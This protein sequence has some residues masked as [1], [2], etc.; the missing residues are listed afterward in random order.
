M[1]HEAIQQLGAEVWQWRNA[2]AFHTGDDIPRVDRAADW[3]P[4]FTVSAIDAMQS[5]HADFH[6]RWLAMDVTTEPVSVQVDYRLVGSALARVIWDIDTLRNWEKDAVFLTSQ[7]L[8]PWFDR[9]LQVPPFSA[10][11]QQALL[12]VAKAIPAQVEVAQAN[13]AR[14]GVGTLARV[15]A[16]MLADVEAQFAESVDKLDGFV[17]AA[18]LEQLRRVTPAAA[19][20]LGQFRDWLEANADSMAADHA[21]GRD[22]FVWFLRNVALIAAEPE[23]M[24][25][26]ARQ[27]YQRAVVSETLVT[28]RYRNLAADRLSDNVGAQVAREAQ[29]EQQVRDFYESENLLTQP[30]SLRHY[31]VGALPDYVKPLRWL[32]VTDDLT[33]EQRLDMDGI[34]YSPDPNPN[35]PY[36][37]AANARDPRLGIVH[38]GA[39][40]QQLALASAH[41]NPLRRRYYDSSANEGIAFYNEEMMMLAG[42]FTDAPHS[43]EVIHNFNRLRSLRVIADVNLATGE[44]SVHDSTQFFVDLVPMDRE[45]ALDESS[46]YVATPGLAMSYHVGKM[47]L[48]R[49]MTDAINQQKDQFSTREFHDYVWLNG[50]VPFSLLRWELLGDR[51]DVDVIDASAS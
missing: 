12:T 51:S 22:K 44:F 4:D 6:E 41:E 42:L 48:I 28:N 24:V 33:S 15:A 25:R 7:I 18:V 8:G 23:D 16:E 11:R 19:A 30:D 27:D 17:D 29:Q 37:Y 26:A 20:A 50:N 39:H 3:L 49:M 1:G 32:G 14:A 35:L 47:L 45:T 46:M 2:T 5:S 10:D 31:L 9:L 13:L 43:E 36:F 40:Y 21:V 38:E 34:S